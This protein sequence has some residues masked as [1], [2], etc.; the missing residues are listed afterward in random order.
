[1]QNDVSLVSFT[2]RSYVFVIT[3]NS[4]VDAFEVEF[5]SL[6]IHKTL[7]DFP[8][9]LLATL[10]YHHILSEQCIDT[11]REPKELGSMLKHSGPWAF[12]SCSCILQHCLL[13]L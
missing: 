4:R 5:C 13:A 1:M 12:V 10:G 2:G 6:D 7:V 9:V 8:S 3:L 11:R